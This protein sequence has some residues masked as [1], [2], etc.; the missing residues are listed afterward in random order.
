MITR[1]SSLPFEERL[2]HYRSRIDRKLSDIL[3]ADRE[4]PERLL[5]AM[6][7]SVLGGGKRVR[8]LLVYAS[9]ELVDAAEEALDSVAAAVELIHAY[10][11]VHDDLPAMDDDDLRRGRPTTHR[12]FDEAAAILAGDALQALAFEVLAADRNLAALP[13][14][15]V[16]ILTW[17]ARAAGPRGMV[18]GQALD[19]EAEGRRVDE[20]ALERIHRGKTGALIR[21]SIMMP[22]ELGELSADERASLD[23]FASEIGLVFQIRDDLLEVEQDTATL[24]KN[25]GSDSG[26][27]KSTYPSTLGIE[28]A[29]QRAAETQQRA[30]GALRTLGPRSDG[31]LWL[32]EFILNRSH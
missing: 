24:G 19:M 7:Y 28:G 11:L 32:S 21:A 5:D 6:R 3:R 29:R 25:A 30:V 26:N 2:D 27:D 17:L 10:S 14:A 13:E 4:V 8:P 20:R 15:Q 9:G 22:S 1:A 12:Q 31:L 16:K 23:L 18:G